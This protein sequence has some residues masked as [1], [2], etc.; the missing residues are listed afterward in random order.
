MSGQW[1]S[2]QKQTENT[3]RRLKAEKKVWYSRY[4]AFKNIKIFKISRYQDIS[5]ISESGVEIL[6]KMKEETSQRIN[7]YFLPNIFHAMY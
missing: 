6:F 3:L 1:L 5:P 4:Q 2:N 7:I